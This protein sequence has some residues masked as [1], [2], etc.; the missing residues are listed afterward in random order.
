[1]L[2]NFLETCSVLPSQAHNTGDLLGQKRGLHGTIRIKN[3]QFKRLILFV[4]ETANRE[5]VILWSTVAFEQIF[6]NTQ[7]SQMLGKRRI[8]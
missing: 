7:P 4:T 5:Y 8:V 6:T 2:L 1:V 3:W